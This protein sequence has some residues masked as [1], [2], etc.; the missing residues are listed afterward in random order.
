MK[1]SSSW[2]LALI[3]TGFVLI[4]VIGTTWGLYSFDTG[5][6]GDYDLYQCIRNNAEDNRF[7]QHPLMI[8]KIQD[9]CVCFRAHNYTNLME[10]DC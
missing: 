10:A 8:Q 3:C 9:E 6:M 2:L 1:P 7:N 4:G 5:T